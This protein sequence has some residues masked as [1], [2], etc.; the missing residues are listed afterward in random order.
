MDPSNPL[1]HLQE[2]YLYMNELRSLPRLSLPQLKILTLNR[3]ADL[4][5]L[6][7]DYCPL[8]EQLQASYCGLKT[9]DVALCP[10]LT[11]LDVSV[12]KL[13]QVSDLLKSLNL[14]SLT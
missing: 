11:H 10:Q 9:L 8:L 4:E 5:H 14:C 12:N 6:A 13:A 3:N 2:V 7:L 1:I